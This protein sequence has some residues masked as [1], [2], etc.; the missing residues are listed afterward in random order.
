MKKIALFSLLLATLA[1][2]CSNLGREVGVYNH[3]SEYLK[4]DQYVAK[5]IVIPSDLSNKN[6][7]E[8]YHVPTIANQGDPSVPALLPPIA[9]NSSETNPKGA[10]V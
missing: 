10:T 3:S 6:M 1:T 9:P 4:T 8:F 5:D 7:E 2:G